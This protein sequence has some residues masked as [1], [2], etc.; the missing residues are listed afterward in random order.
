MGTR[1]FHKSLSQHRGGCLE[2]PA[3]PRPLPTTPATWESHFISQIKNPFCAV[4]NRW[5]EHWEAGQRTGSWLGGV[6][7]DTEKTAERT[8]VRSGNW[9]GR[10]EAG[11]HLPEQRQD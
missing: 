11:G 7:Q 6:F 1:L 5:D 8:L 9:L 2:A 4:N 10:V 3:F